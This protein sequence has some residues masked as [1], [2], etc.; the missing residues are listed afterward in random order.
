[1]DFK[2]KALDANGQII[3]DAIS[4]ESQTEAINIIRGRRQQLIKLDMDEP[5]GKDVELPFLKKK[6]KLPDLTVFCKQLS[7]MLH[8]GIPLSRA[9]D[10]QAQQTVNKQMQAVLMQVS[11]YIKQGLPLS[12]AMRKFP[13]IFPALLLNMIEAGELTGKLDETLARMHEHYSNEHK[14]NSKIKGAMI[15][16]MVLAILTASVIVLMLTFVMPMFS[17]MFASSGVKLPLPTRIMIALSYGLRNYWYIIIAVIGVASYGIK[18]FIKTEQGKR[19]FDS[20]VL[21]LPVVK[22]LMPQIITARFTRTLSTLLSSGISI[23]KA[24]ESATETT[25][26]VIVMEEMGVVINDVKKGQ[27]VS[28]LLKRVSVFPAMM[29][30]M[31]SVGEETGAVDDM[32]KKTADYYDEVLESAIGKLVALLE[33]VMIIFMGISIGGIV[34][35][36]YLPMFGM[37]ETMNL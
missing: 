30:S 32:L 3:N 4:A 31:I 36:M 2:Y 20:I 34:V 12:K 7:T 13:D 24:L 22:I 35:A 15:Y 5:K 29:V 21:K 14:I 9:L 18:R 28:S 1:L 11:S 25:N 19:M 33:P 6:V 16:P 23:I 8:A 37:F 27:S 26:N 10:I 17:E